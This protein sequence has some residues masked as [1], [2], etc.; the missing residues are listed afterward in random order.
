[1]GPLPRCPDPERIQG[2]G[3]QEEG[4]EVIWND[5]GTGLGALVPKYGEVGGLP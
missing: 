1:M 4:E 2:E 3:G 5:R